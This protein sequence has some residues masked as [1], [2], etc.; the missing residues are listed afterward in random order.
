MVDHKL[1]LDPETQKLCDQR[2]MKLK[3]REL[4]KLFKKTP[5]FPLKQVLEEIEE[6]QRKHNKRS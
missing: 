2:L 4:R 6:T 5:A 3:P 1:Q